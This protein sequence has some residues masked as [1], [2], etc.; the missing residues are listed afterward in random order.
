MHDWGVCFTNLPTQTVSETPSVVIV[1]YEF[2]KTLL[3]DVWVCEWVWLRAILSLTITPW[4]FFSQPLPPLVAN[5][6]CECFG[7]VLVSLLSLSERLT[8]SLL[9]SNLPWC[10]LKG[11]S[12]KTKW[13]CCDGESSSVCCVCVLLSVSWWPIKAQQKTSELNGISSSDVWGTNS[14]WR[15]ISVKLCFRNLNFIQFF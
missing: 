4:G 13:H 12:G 7:S 15:Q 9:I 10:S 6:S 11:R 5:N 8:A 1:I 14:D 2:N 3:V